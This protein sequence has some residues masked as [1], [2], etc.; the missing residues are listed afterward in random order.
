MRAVFAIAASLAWIS[1]L[2]AAE[3]LAGRKP[4]IVLV[5]ADDQG[6]GDMAY[7]GHAH[8]KTPNFDA[9]AKETIRFDFFHAAAPVCSPQAFITQG[10]FAATQ[11]TSSMPRAVSEAMT[12][13]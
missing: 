7:N 13:M 6:W 1:D 10:S 12:R 4:N 2:S 8:L 9:M 3:P 11:M 5:M